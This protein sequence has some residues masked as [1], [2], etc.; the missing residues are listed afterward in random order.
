MR[1]VLCK[2]LEFTDDD[3]RHEVITGPT[4]INIYA[5]AGGE[6]DVAADQAQPVLPYFAELDALASETNANAA[7]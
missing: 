4:V 3:G 1:R 2:R 7:D 5:P 6:Q